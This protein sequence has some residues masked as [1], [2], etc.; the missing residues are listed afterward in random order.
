MNMTLRRFAALLERAAAPAATA[1]D[2]ERA[3][4]ADEQRRRERGPS[5]LARR[6]RRK[7]ELGHAGAF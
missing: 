6:L 4:A 3:V 7:H 5:K 1:L 2:F